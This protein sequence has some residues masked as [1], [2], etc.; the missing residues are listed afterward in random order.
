MAT[1]KIT[2]T[3]RD[4]ITRKAAEPFEN[5]ITKL[6]TITNPKDADLLYATVV[7]PDLEQKLCSLPKE[8]SINFGSEMHM[9]V[10]NKEELVIPLYLKFKCRPYIYSWT[11]GASHP[12]S[13][14]G[15]SSPRPIGVEGHYNPYWPKIELGIF[16]TLE[17]SVDYIGK[18]AELAKDRDTL[19]AG[20]NKVLDSVPTIN[21]AMKF[22]PA[23]ETYLS[24]EK[25]AKLHEVTER[26]SASKIKEELNLDELNVA[27]ITQRMTGGV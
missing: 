22:W 8:W 26:K 2:P 19:L 10:N 3:L 27:H 16:N 21:S 14:G 15:W 20:I 17:L 23:I 6:L 11:H 5:A 9:R 13:K 24:D 18:C 12:P 4:E 1:L 7:P 25:K